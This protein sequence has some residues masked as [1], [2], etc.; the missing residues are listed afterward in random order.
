V[1]LQS[2]IP[3]TEKNVGK[4]FINTTTRTRIRRTKVIIARENKQ[5]LD[6]IIKGA[7]HE[8]I[9][10][11][12]GL[13]EKNY[14]KRIAAIRKRDMELTKSEQTP[15]AHAFLYK[16][17]EEKLHNLEAMTLQIAESEAEQAKDRI[18]AMRFLR[19]LFVDQYSLFLYGPSQF[20]TRD[21][22]AS[23]G[24]I[25]DTLRSFGPRKL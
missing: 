11:W 5:I 6:Y 4:S 10:N 16:R 20:L 22:N 23:G 1:T 21:I 14:W 24:S 8:Q 12:V 18:E 13:K 9:M 7:T 17:T 19:Q 2:D 15:E 3:P 25:T